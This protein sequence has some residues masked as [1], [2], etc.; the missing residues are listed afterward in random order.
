MNEPL[1]VALVAGE[2]SGDQLGAGLIA[3]LRKQLGDRPVVFEGVAGPAMREAGCE[4]WHDCTAL[5]VMGLAE[6]VRHLPRLLLLRR[7]LAKR[8]IASPPDVFIGIDAPDFN[9]GL[10]RRLRKHGI[11][12]VHYVSPSVWAWR[13][14]RA[15]AMA[16]ST[17]LV[18]CLLPFE[19]DFYADYGLRAVFV[20]H[21][22]ADSLPL[23]TNPQAARSALG[24]PESGEIVALLPGSRSGEIDRL[25]E[26]FAG[27]AALLTERRPGIRFV[28]PMASPAIGEKF[29]AELAHHGRDAE[30]LLLDR[31]AQQAIAA[32]DVVLV[33][34]GTATLEALLLKRPMVVAYRLA[35]ATRI[36]LEKLALL[37]IERF[38]LPNLLAGRDLVPEILQDELSAARLAEEV[39]VLLGRRDHLA[40]V[41]EC[42][43]IHGT[44]QRDASARAAEAVTE[45]CGWR[46]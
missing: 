39:S 36:V 5:A 7:R 14:K 15:E 31:Q 21:P 2:A 29:A 30:V 16:E 24:L 33:A 10:E 35:Q 27:A 19:P 17:D 42:D 22:L 43:A 13:P 3:A 4:S 28:A 11:P 23:R 20:G 32:A 8:L 41:A 38:A 9:L 34:S 46:Q 37:N 18:L 40:Y 25:G 6:V 26:A 12:T 45:L 1:R 44:L